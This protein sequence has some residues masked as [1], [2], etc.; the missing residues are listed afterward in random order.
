MYPRHFLCFKHRASG[1]CFPT[2]TAC[3]LAAA[4]ANEKN[5][6]RTHSVQCQA[7]RGIQKQPGQVVHPSRLPQINRGKC[8]HR[9]TFMTARMA[10]GIAQIPSPIK[11]PANVRSQGNVV[12]VDS[13]HGTA[14]MRALSP[15]SACLT[16]AHNGPKLLSACRAYPFPDVHDDGTKPEVKSTIGSNV[17]LRGSGRQTS[18]VRVLKQVFSLSPWEQ[19]AAVPT[20]MPMAMGLGT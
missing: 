10:E 1:C 18:T 3:R 2:R 7:R 4:P 14:T 9:L 16:C 11:K 19:T 12:N 15:A 8:R 20:G 5:K 6:A 13:C 17:E